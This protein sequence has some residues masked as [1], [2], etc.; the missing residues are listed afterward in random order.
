MSH[1][2]TFRNIA[3]RRFWGRFSVITP[4][5]R[6]THTPLGPPMPLT[7]FDLQN[8]KPAAKPFKIADGGGLFLIVQPN[9]SKHWRLRYF[10]L[11]KERSLSIGAYP[12]VSLAEARGARE[13]AKRQIAAGAD[14][15]VQKKLARIAA[16]A[17]S[18]NT[19]GLIAV[20]YLERLE[21]NGASPAT[22]KKN[23]WFLEESGT[24][25]RPPPYRRDHRR[26]GARPFA[27]DREER[28]SRNR[29]SDAGRHRLSF[30]IGDR[31][32]AG[33][34]RPH[35]C[36]AR[37]ALAPQYEAPRGDH[38]RAGV[39]R[40]L[41][42][43]RRLRRLADHQGGASIFGA[44]LR[45]P[46]RGSRREARR[47]QLRKGALADSARAHEDAPAARRSPLPPSHRRASRDLA[48]RRK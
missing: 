15:S 39:W 38:R 8:A 22:L 17:A 45:P 34:E 27:A 18:N 47:D 13:H 37:C 7:H 14:P 23:R 16:A 40:P 2:D 19:F 9:G 25:D 31:H 42:R 20:E 26:R 5:A 41:A 4:V 33:D 36:A 1:R 24:A 48:G 21:A 12:L 32:A 10:Y 11:G 29:T 43:D 35:P 6:G 44:D 46:G 3:S 28:P 30:P